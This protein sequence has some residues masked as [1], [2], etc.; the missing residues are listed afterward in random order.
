M[1]QDI[2]TLL[3]AMSPPDLPQELVLMLCQA[4]QQELELALKP[5]ITPRDCRDAFLPAAAF[6]TLARLQAGSGEQGVRSF[7]AGDVSI[8]RDSGDAGISALTDQ[9]RAL[10]APYTT[11]SSFLFLEVMG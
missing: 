10:M 8:Q 1:T 3:Q 9:A 2:L 5:G 7:T 11:D 4:A 6:L